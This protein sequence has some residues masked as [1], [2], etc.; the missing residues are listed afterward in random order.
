LRAQIA[1]WQFSLRPSSR[2]SF[3]NRNRSAMTTY[4]DVFN[5]LVMLDVEVPTVVSSPPN[6][7]ALYTSPMELSLTVL[8]SFFVVVGLGVGGLV[9]WIRRR[10][11]T[12]RQAALVMAAL[13][14]VWVFVVGNGLEIRENARI[15]WMVE[16]V[17]L[18]VLAVTIERF[19][20]RLPRR[21]RR[22]TAR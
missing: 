18:A 21:W 3:L 14:V 2:Y 4:N 7:R 8:G 19:V 5:R 1:S 22:V 16:P 11:L 10:A 12:G 20:R 15:R 6:V 17:M 9:S 13:T